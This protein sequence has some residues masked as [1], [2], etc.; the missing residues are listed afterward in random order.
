M[1]AVRRMAHVPAT[2]VWERG[3]QS[4]RFRQACP[5]AHF[6]MSGLT[7]AHLSSPP[8]RPGRCCCGDGETLP[9]AAPVVHPDDWQHSAVSCLPAVRHDHRQQYPPALSVPH[10]SDAHLRVHTSDQVDLAGQLGGPWQSS[11]LPHGERVQGEEGRMA[12]IAITKLNAL[13]AV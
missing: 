4:D 3:L 9:H 5:P 11:P 13:M 10:R 1:Q 2:V 12:E 8:L 6:C 7:C